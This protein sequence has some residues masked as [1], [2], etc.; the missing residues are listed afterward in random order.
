MI[1]PRIIP[2]IWLTLAVAS[3][4]AV[5]GWA[6]WPTD[7]VVDPTTSPAT[8][9]APTAGHRLIGQK[10]VVR[11]WA[12]EDSFADL[13]IYGDLKQGFEEAQRTGKPV[14]VTY[15]CVP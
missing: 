15:R 1:S 3:S 2:S 10:K 7:E 14:L 11:R 12:D 4:L 9:Q 13:W 6:L 5:L 8:R